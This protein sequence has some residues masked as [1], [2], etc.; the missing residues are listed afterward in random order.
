LYEALAINPSAMVKVG[1]KHGGLKGRQLSATK[2]ERRLFS[3]GHLVCI[4]AE[5][6]KTIHVGLLDI[7]SNLVNLVKEFTQPLFSLFNFQEFADILKAGINCGFKKCETKDLVISGHDQ[8][9]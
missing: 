9:I 2:T 5:T 3:R 1:I 8:T 6:E 4:E 7:K